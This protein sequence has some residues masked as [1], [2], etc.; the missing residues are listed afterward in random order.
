[1]VSDSGNK[2]DTR[3]ITYRDLENYDYALPR[4]ESVCYRSN[5]MTAG[6]FYSKKSVE[7]DFRELSKKFGKVQV[8]SYSDAPRNLIKINELVRVLEEAGEVEIVSSQHSICT[9]YNAQNKIQENLTEF[10][11][12]LRK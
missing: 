4:L 6:R 5:G 10:F 9:Q 1:M 7:N 12:I 3:D 11:L 8:Y 2:R